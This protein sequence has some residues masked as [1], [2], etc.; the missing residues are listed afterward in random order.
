MPW[1]TGHRPH[2]I[3][4]DMALLIHEIPCRRDG[5][6]LLL[7]LGNRVSL[8]GEHHNSVGNARHGQVVE[9]LDG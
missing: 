1:T 6:L 5:L 3:F 8:Y 9:S 7:D 2:R 4:S